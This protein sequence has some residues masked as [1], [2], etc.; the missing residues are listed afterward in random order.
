MILQLMTGIFLAVVVTC[1]TS[2]RAHGHALFHQGC[3]TAVLICI[4]LCGCVGSIMV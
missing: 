4:G 2:M 3:P 1:E